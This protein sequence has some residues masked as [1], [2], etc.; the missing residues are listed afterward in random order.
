MVREGVENE[1]RERKEG[2]SYLKLKIKYS[3]IQTN[4]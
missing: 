4:S 1:K 3:N 2:G